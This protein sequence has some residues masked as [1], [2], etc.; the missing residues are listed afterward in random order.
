MAALSQP[1]FARGEISPSLYGRTDTAAYRVALRTARNIN[2]RQYGG[3]ENRA[4]LQFI[5]PV[6]DHTKAV[7]VIP[8]QFKATDAYIIEMGNLYM[9]FIRNDSYVTETAVN[10][11]GIT[12]ANPAVV[13][14]T[15]HGYS[16]GDQVYISG[17]SGMTEVN[18]KWYKIANQTTN[19][20]ELTTQ[21]T[22]S[23]VDSSGYTAYSSGGTSEK[24][25][26]ITTTY[27]EA[28][29]FE[30]K[31][32]Q[33]ADVMTLVHPSYP[34][35][36]LT[37]TAH[38]S[39]TLT[40]VSFEPDQPDPIDIVLTNN[41]AAGSTTYIYKVTATNAETG[42]ESLPG[43]NNS[44][45]TLASATAAN[46]VV[47]TATSHG[48]LDGDEVE[49][50]G[51][52]EMTEVNGRRFIV[53]NKTTNTFELEDEDGTSYTAESTGGTANLTHVSISNGNASA[54]NTITFAEATG[55]GSYSIY[56]YDNGIYG[57]IGET[58]ELEFTD[59]GIA[60]DLDITPPKARNPFKGTGNYPGAVSYY[61][62]RRVFGGSTNN[63]D[64]TYYSQTGHQNNFSVHSPTQADD[65][66]TATLNSLEV[67]E[68]QHFVPSNDLL[69]LTSGSEWRVNDGSENAFS[70]TTIRQKPQSSWGAS[71]IRPLVVGNTTLFITRSR[72]RVRSLGYDL[73]LDG[74][75]GEEVSLFA[76]HLTE[77]YKITDWDIIKTLSQI[78]LVRED[79]K[80][81]TLTFQPEQQVVAWSTWDTDGKFES[82]ASIYP[83]SD[84][85]EDTAYLVI[86]RTI[87]G[88][89]VRY[90]EKYHTRRF[91]DVKDCFFV[92]SGLSLDS[93]IA[94]SGATAASPVVITTS[95]A[96]GL[97]NGDY[98][99]ISDI[100]WETDTDDFGGK[101]QP[102]Q[103]N[104]GRFIVANKTSTTFELTDLSGTNIDGSAYNAYIEGGNVRKAVTTLS[105]LDHLEGET[106]VVLADGSVVENL[107]V[108]S[109]SVTLSF[110]ASRV[111]VGL[112]YTSDIETLDI[113]LPDNTIADR[114]KKVT[115][116]TFKFENSRGLF[117]GNDYT[118]MDELKQ[119]ENETYGEPTALFTGPRTVHIPPEWTE[120]GR[121][122][123]RQRY[124]LPMSVLAIILD[125][126]VGD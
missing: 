118:R 125:I 55:A 56:K 106:V 74:Y 108:S 37:R 21:E 23:N 112:P 70:P 80:V 1:S 124:P 99:D 6:K 65:A 66:I 53:A 26:E 76:S 32:V 115:Q 4:G 86:Q 14:A 104:G 35:M 69:V 38:T 25:Y 51:F 111:H 29:L 41:A 77:D 5:G 20:F 71:Y 63:P 82:V 7:R 43:L 58:E 79:G 109:G 117:Y 105:G 52:N 3:A 10:I 60:A 46:P 57:F 75:K 49:I 36:E 91:T 126:E 16:N 30:I 31:H 94:I 18:G 121:V 34:I 33:S 40:E 67:N 116:V 83:A 81:L 45:V 42:E 95:T 122:V 39:W 15:S 114:K 113:E 68:I 24:V 88:N 44:D 9:R 47:V 54:D 100:T 101:S 22:G 123:A 48:L 85:I 64:T 19:T 59:D 50:N 102:S 90:I 73:T 107:T 87:N 96:H 72:A 93:P 120:T 17:V 61:E 2:I 28:D 103:L 13:T 98:V 8:F 92:D 62:Q 89:S 119:R 12:Q 84:S 110:R 78:I 27:V 97:E 11:T